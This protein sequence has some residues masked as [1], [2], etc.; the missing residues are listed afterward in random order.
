MLQPFL[1]VAGQA[2]R[3]PR[4]AATTL[5]SMG[6]PR[7][8]LWPAFGALVALSVILISVGG[9]A[10][11][12]VPSATAIMS[13]FAL[14]TMSGIAGAASVFAVWKVGASMG[15]T[16]S[17]QETLL[18]TVFLQ[19]IIFAG[20]LIELVL[21]FVMPP[22]AGLFSIGLVVLTFW[23]NINFIAALHGFPSLWKALGVLLLASLG[24]ALVLI[25]AMSLFGVQVMGLA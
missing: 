18:L 6:V 21:V 19:S 10:P 12:A 20:Q 2:L 5:L 25:F 23:L 22:I 3:E 13:P 16:G 1:P 24:V 11:S 4:E 17:L 8:A 9:L 14:A 15:G 7:S